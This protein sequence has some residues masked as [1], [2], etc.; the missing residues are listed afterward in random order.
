M[1][2]KERIFS[3]KIEKGYCLAVHLLAGTSVRGTKKDVPDSTFV[4][5]GA[6]K[7]SK[8]HRT[9]NSVG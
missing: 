5:A 6:V 9:K 8:N 4:E 2:L 1:F 3:E 7:T